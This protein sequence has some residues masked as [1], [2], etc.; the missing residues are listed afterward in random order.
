MKKIFP[1]LLILIL[2]MFSGCNP[3]ED[4]G[5]LK[6]VA[7]IYPIYDFAL[8]IGGEK[9]NAV[10]ITEGID[11]HGFEPSNSQMAQIMS[12]KV[13]LYNGAGLESWVDVV[14]DYIEG[15][16]VARAASQ[17]VELLDSEGDDAGEHQH[18]VDPHIWLYPQNAKIMAQNIKEALC[19]ADAEN[20]GYYNANYQALIEELDE[21]DAE[22]IQNLSGV[23]LDTIAV[24][25]N[26]F[27]YMCNAYNLRQIALSGI[28]D[29]HDYS[30]GDLQKIIAE[31]NQ[32]NIKVVFYNQSDGPS[33][34]NAL[35]ENSNAED[36]MLLST[37]AS[38]SSEQR[39]GGDDYFSVMRQNL[40]ALKY[41]L[42]G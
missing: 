30:A 41:A 42:G 27:G 38:L 6:V 22:Y 13:F 26:A 23:A 12:C 11:A 37:L 25:H 29:E 2:L 8:K 15:S 7:T 20:A 5:R 40:E 18:A 34:A 21:L 39:A 10:N 28:N 36:A 16:A 33:S 17:G 9:V 1:L 31:I 24:T 4:D 3:P 14:L 35:I 32:K 19:S